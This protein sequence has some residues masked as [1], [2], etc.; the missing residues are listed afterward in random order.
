[1]DRKGRGDMLQQRRVP[2]PPAAQ[3]CAAKPLGAVRRRAGLR[4][5]ITV[6]LLVVAVIHAWLVPEHLREAPYVGWFF[7]AL[8][9]ACLVLIGLLATTRASV[10]L[11]ATVLVMALSIAAYVES[12]TIGLPQMADDVGNWGEPLAIV[13]LVAESVTVL[14]AIDMLLGLS[15]RRAHG[16]AR[17]P[18]VRRERRK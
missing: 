14:T 3:A 7:L 2:T 12:R 9:L 1:M 6:G 11:G 4:A 13:S 10:A 16:R 8:A 15:P 18:Q 5:A 17:R